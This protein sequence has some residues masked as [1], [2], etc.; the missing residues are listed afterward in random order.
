MAATAV[1]AEQA[2]DDFRRRI[3]ARPAFVYGNEFLRWARR[4]KND[5]KRLPDT[6]T[7]IRRLDSLLERFAQ[8]DF[9]PYEEIRH[10]IAA[11]R[12]PLG[13]N[14][15][16]QLLT[17]AAWIDISDATVRILADDARTIWNGLADA[18]GLLRLDGFPPLSDGLGASIAKNGF[19]PAPGGLVPG[20]GS[21]DSRRPDAVGMRQGGELGER[22]RELVDSVRS[23][24]VLSRLL[25]VVVNHEPY[26]RIVVA[27]IATETAT[28]VDL[29]YEQPARTAPEHR[30]APLVEI[31]RR[32]PATPGL[33]IVERGATSLDRVA[34][35]HVRELRRSIGAHV[36]EDQTVGQLM[37]AV[38]T[39]KLSAVDAVVGNC[40]ATISEAR[41]ADLRL[42]ILRLIDRPITGLERVDDPPDP[43]Y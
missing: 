8:H 41:E 19:D 1:L 43:G 38:E 4:A 21:F 29:L 5:L 6:R 30:H 14:C 23:V 37:R 18:Y 28:L 12:Q 32:E 25:T 34:L 39:V 7:T 26:W 11:H 16:D 22:G 3:L 17:E 10:R 24:Q 36:D 42:A 15:G 33:A 2:P 27:A 31:L 9:G 35:E 20:V 13:A 40:F